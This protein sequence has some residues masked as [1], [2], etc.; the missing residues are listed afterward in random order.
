YRKYFAFSL[1]KQSGSQVT[2][3]CNLTSPGWSHDLLGNNWACIK[4][5]KVSN[6]EQKHDLHQTFI[7]VGKNHHLRPFLLES[8]D[9][10]EF[11]SDR[12]VRMVNLKQ[13]SWTAKVYPHFREKSSEELI[14]MAGG[15]ASRLA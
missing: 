2:S 5:R 12:F 4:G 8:V 10:D 6:W 9:M 11:L 3:Y 1:Y 7:G 13:S 14:R 15:R